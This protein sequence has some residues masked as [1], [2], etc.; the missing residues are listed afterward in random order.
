MTYLYLTEMHLFLRITLNF[1]FI[2]IYQMQ[3]RLHALEKT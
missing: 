2:K 3:E 1:L